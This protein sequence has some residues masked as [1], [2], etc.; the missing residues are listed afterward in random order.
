MQTVL[1]I[2]IIII[3][4][5]LIFPTFFFLSR[6]TW[7]DS[8]GLVFGAESG[9]KWAFFF[10]AADGMVYGDGL[11]RKT[12]N[13][14]KGEKERGEGK[15]GEIGREVFFRGVEVEDKEQRKERGEGK[16]YDLRLKTQVWPL[17]ALSFG[18]SCFSSFHIAEFKHILL[19]FVIVFALLCSHSGSYVLSLKWLRIWFTF[20]FFLRL[21]FE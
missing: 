3:Y 12:E 16:S 5:F 7:W 14:G 20:F 15:G 11:L 9:L 13:R 1:L 8:S 21:M 2:I 6:S 18:T 19:G 17:W 4:L 10:W